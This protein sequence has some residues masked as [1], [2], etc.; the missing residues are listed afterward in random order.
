MDKLQ[1]CVPNGTQSPSAEPSKSSLSSTSSSPAHPTVK[2]LLAPSVTL[3][4][5]SWNTRKHSNVKM[6]KQL[7]ETFSGDLVTDAILS[8][9]AKLFSEN[10]GTW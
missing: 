7:Y 9:A 2:F 5:S 4:D 1:G 10:Y 8:E 6:E 3:I